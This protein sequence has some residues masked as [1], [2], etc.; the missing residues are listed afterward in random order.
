MNAN[1]HSIWY[2]PPSENVAECVGIELHGGPKRFFR[3]WPGTLV[4]DWG[5]RL[6][7]SAGPIWAVGQPS[8]SDLEAAVRAELAYLW[9]DLNEAVRSAINGHWSI[10]C[11][12]VVDRI[13]TL[14][15]LVGATP[16]GEVPMT[17][18]ETGLYQRIHEELGIE[19]NP[20]MAEV[21]RLQKLT[22]NT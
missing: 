13:K 20:D 9:N 8:P 15:R 5:W 12:S 18:L 3:L 10:R 2:Q 21:A 17:L 11:D 7:Q 4:Q 22:R 1:V 16:W 19:V 6:H 14:I